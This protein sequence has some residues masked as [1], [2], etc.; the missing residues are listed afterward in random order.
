M[1]SSS[2]TTVGSDYTKNL[3]CGFF[4]VGVDGVRKSYYLFFLS[5]EEWMR[6]R[7]PSLSFPPLEGRGL[8]ERVKYGYSPSLSFP[9]VKGGKN[10]NADRQ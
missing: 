4:S 5:S 6:R 2:F 1:A 3:F 8:K 7:T 10:L 9:P